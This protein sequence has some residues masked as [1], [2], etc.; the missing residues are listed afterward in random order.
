MMVRSARFSYWS[1]NEATVRGCGASASAQKFVAWAGKAMV[2]RESL[3]E[4]CMVPNSSNH[5][6]AAIA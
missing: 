1:I 6:L 3:S 5:Q 2:G 4:T